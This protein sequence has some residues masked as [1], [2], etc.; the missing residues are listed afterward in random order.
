MKTRPLLRCLP[1]LPTALM[2]RTP[3]TTHAAPPASGTWT[4]TG[5]LHQSGAFQ[6]TTSLPDAELRAGCMVAR[7]FPTLRIILR[8]CV[9]SGA[10]Q[11]VGQPVTIA[12][13]K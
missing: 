12:G 1:V 8:I 2:A 11:T 10:A 7:I 4:V 13:Q 9:A 3:R 6:T 5:S